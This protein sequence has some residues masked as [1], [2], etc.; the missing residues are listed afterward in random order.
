MTWPI[1]KAIAALEALG[2][3]IEMGSRVFYS[4]HDPTLDRIRM[5]AFKSGELLSALREMADDAGRV[6]DPHAPL[7]NWTR[8]G[9]DSLSSLLVRMIWPDECGK[10]EVSW[11]GGD[12]RPTIVL[13]PVSPCRWFLSIADLRGPGG[14]DW[15]PREW[16]QSPPPVGGSGA[17]TSLGFPDITTYI[18]DETI[19]KHRDFFGAPRSVP[20][21]KPR[22]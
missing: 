5:I 14:G 11:C 17:V 10:F 16:T 12:N 4:H 15:D 3:H 1:Q 9:V 13:A 18:S 6:Q 19:D 7:W 21:R 2:P 22:Q 20:P 8:R